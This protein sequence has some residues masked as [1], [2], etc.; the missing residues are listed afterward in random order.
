MENVFDLVEDFYAQDPEW[1]GVLQQSYVENFLR[2]KAW[3]GAGEDELVQAWD[4]ITI[5]C[6]YLGN[7]ENF[8]GDMSRENFIDCVGWCARN[9]SDFV[10]TAEN[11]GA[12]FDTMI[13]LYAHLKKKHIITGDG[14]PAEAKAK[15]LAGGRVQ[16]LKPDGRFLPQYDRYNV[17]ATPD[18]PAKIFLNIG[19]RLQ[20]L[21][22][23]LQTFFSHKRYERDVERATFLYSGILMSGAVEEKP[24]SEEYAQCFWDYFLFDYHMIADDKIPLQHFYDNICADSFSVQGRVSRDVLLELLQARLVLFTVEGRTEDGLYNCCNIFTGEQYMLML[25]IGGKVETKDMVF[26]GHIFYNQSMV[27]NF[28]RGMLMP[29]SAFKRFQKVM[30]QAKDWVAV[31]QREPMSWEDFISRFPIFVRHLSLLY[32]AYVRLG[33]FDYSTAVT[34]YEPQPV[35]QDA[36]SA[37]IAKMMQPYAFSA[38]DI[39]L[40]QTMW[41]DYLELAQRPAGSVR[42]PEIW[43]AGIIYNFIQCNGVYNYDSRHISDMCF[44]VPVS[45]IRRTAKEMERVILL[46]EHD[47]RYIN[48]EGLLLMLLS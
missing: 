8:L 21:M 44:G 17:Y 7:S 5:L 22:E 23:S 9:V 40:A 24:G 39:Q 38:Y 16:M 26:L 27:M 42:V 19:D 4:H 29:K 14:A 15:L 33:G 35:R 13:E 45:T 20:D 18:L 41:S 30:Q 48:E 12:F 47:P 31:R 25:P 11:V 34:A 32:S 2:M 6:I 28:V 36:V 10:L 3:Q 46:E 1:N 37:C 43:A